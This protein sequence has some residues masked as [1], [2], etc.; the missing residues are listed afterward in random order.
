MG[1]RGLNF[2]R[3]NVDEGESVDVMQGGGSASIIEGVARNLREPVER[4]DRVV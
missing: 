3:G 1:C 4:I 2:P